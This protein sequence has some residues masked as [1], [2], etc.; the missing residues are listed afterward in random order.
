LLGCVRHTVL[1]FSY[2][3]LFAVPRTATL[4]DPLVA[5]IPEADENEANGKKEDADDTA[6]E[7]EIGDKKAKNT[8][9]GHYCDKRELNEYKV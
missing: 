2:F 3:C 8:G 1:L 6:D 5:R 7:D 9:G 4:E